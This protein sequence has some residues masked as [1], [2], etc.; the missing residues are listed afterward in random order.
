VQLALR[1]GRS[2]AAQWHLARAVGKRFQW[3]R[4]KHLYV[5]YGLSTP[6]SIDIREQSELS[7]LARLFLEQESP[8]AAGHVCFVD[9]PFSPLCGFGVIPNIWV[10]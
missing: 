6:I 8:Y 4:A 1:Y 9:K 5:H 2:W 10:M 7:E 3:C